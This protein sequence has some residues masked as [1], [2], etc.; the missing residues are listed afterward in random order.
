MSTVT[1][2]GKVRWQVFEGAINADILIDFM[3]R[4]IQDAKGKK[5]FLILDNLRVHHAKPVKAWLAEHE[6]QIEVFYL[7]SYSPEF[8]PDEEFCA[9]LKAAVT[10]KAPARAKGEL[11]KA[12]VSPLRRLQ[13]TP[14][15][16]MRY[17]QHSPVH[18]AA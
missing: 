14:S 4:L 5:V 9:D 1:N 13:K 18:Y 7:P 15:R 3:K 6:Q 12:T 2:R 16:V 11:K 10:R 8:N 17:F